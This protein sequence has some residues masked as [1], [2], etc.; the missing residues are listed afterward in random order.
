[1]TETVD[2]ERSGKDD[3]GHQLG[4]SP[5]DGAGGLGEGRSRGEDTPR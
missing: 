3:D 1:M 5:T 2:R 4:E